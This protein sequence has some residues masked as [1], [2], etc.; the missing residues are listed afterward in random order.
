MPISDA[1]N[2][3]STGVLISSTNL[4][5][6]ELSED[7]ETMSIGPGPRWGDVFNYLEFTNKTVIG[8]DMHL[9]GFLGSFLVGELVGTVSSMVWLLPVERSRLTRFEPPLNCQI[10]VANYFVRLSSQTEQSPP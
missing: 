9:L 2:I 3:N 8:G 1:A 4:N 5:A 10:T 6:L 7:K